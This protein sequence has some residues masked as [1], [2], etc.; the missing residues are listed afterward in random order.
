M[1]DDDE[2]ERLHDNRQFV[3]PNYTK[4]LSSRASK[5]ALQVTEE[6]FPLRIQCKFVPTNVPQRKTDVEVS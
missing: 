2:Q 4:V 3:A 6:A 5:T 1:T